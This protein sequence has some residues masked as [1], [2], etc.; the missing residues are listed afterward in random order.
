MRL[1]GNKAMVVGGLLLLLG[2]PC[3]GD[4]IEHDFGIGTRSQDVF[5]LGIGFGH[6]YW[7]PRLPPGVP[8]PKESA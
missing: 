1:S 7:P 2:F 4:G 8:A 5:H 3:A 6:R